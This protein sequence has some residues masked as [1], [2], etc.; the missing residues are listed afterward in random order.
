M[1][2][3]SEMAVKHRFDRVIVAGG[4]TSG[5]VTLRLGY[6]AY[7][8]GDS[9][10]PGVPVMRPLKNLRLSLILKSGNFGD[11][12]FFEKALWEDRYEHG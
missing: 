12:D 11:E 2:D 1:A 9:V 7:Q 10:A 4:E 6:A 8:I 3:L 5:A